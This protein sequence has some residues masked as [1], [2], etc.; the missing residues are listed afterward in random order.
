MHSLVNQFSTQ[1]QTEK[2][3]H[4]ELDTGHSPLCHGELGSDRVVC[5]SGCEHASQLALSTPAG[6]YWYCYCCRGV[7]LV[8]ELSTSLRD[9][10]RSPA[11]KKAHRTRDRGYFGN[12]K[13]LKWKIFF[14]I[15]LSAL[16]TNYFCSL[17][18]NPNKPTCVNSNKIF[19][20]AKLQCA[21]SFKRQDH[22]G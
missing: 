13:V 17:S 20:H 14:Y 12:K 10:Y 16:K 15:D 19:N 7:G 18:K 3:L 5:P 11:P 6:W 22:S 4:E 8:C 1:K 21:G 9:R 2:A